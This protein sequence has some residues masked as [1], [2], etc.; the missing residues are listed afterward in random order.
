MR[1]DKYYIEGKRKNKNMVTNMHMM[2]NFNWIFKW[3]IILEYIDKIRE[4]LHVYNYK[5]Q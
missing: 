1:Q 3:N 2:R 4:V 5:A